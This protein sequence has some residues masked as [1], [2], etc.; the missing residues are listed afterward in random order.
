MTADSQAF[1]P[2]AVMF[3]CA[4]P[5]SLRRILSGTCTLVTSINHWLAIFE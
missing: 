3:I 2:P 1:A 4:C 5:A